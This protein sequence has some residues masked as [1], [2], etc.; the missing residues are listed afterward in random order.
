[1]NSDDLFMNLDK[2][3]TK[4]NVNKKIFQDIS[5]EEIPRQTKRLL[6]ELDR[7]KDRNYDAADIEI[8]KDIY[9]YFQAFDE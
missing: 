6:A 1:M 8:M 2:L 7:N 5:E 9:F 3:Y 4:Y